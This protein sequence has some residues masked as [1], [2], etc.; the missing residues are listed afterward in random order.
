MKG[1]TTFFEQYSKT[2]LPLSEAIGLAERFN[3]PLATIEKAALQ[4]NI[5]PTRHS[6]NCFSCKE[7]LKLLKSHV[8][9]IGCGGLGG[10]VAMQLGRLGIGNLH[11]VDPDIFEE[12]NLNRQEFCTLESLGQP[13]V[14]AARKSLTRINPALTC[15]TSYALF[16]DN[17]LKPGI[18]IDCLDNVGTRRELA[19]LCRRKD[20]LLIHGAVVEWYGRIGSVTAENRLFDVLYPENKQLPSSKPPKVLAPTVYQTASLQVAETIK[21]L[22]GFSQTAIH[23]WIDC[24]LKNSNLEHIDYTDH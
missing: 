5:M 12:H 3:H 7:Q 18:I 10:A 21:H 6:R 15:T 4:Y 19:Q 11:L 13:K 14:I 2:E 8:T 9:V 1:L 24:D 23:H 17:D 20:L 22:L 16:S